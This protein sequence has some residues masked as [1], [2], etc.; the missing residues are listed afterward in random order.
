MNLEKLWQQKG[1]GISAMLKRYRFVLLV[2]LVGAVF[3]LLPS[4]SAGQGVAAEVSHEQDF[5]LEELEDKFSRA[6]SEI[7]GAG[8]V[9]VVLTV[10][11]GSQRILAEDI[12]YTQKDSD[13]EREQATVILAKGSGVQEAVTVQEVYPQFQGALV[14]C[15]GGND[16]DVRLKLTEATVALT[17]LSTDKISICSRGK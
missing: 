4:G 13:L 8:T 17:G 6:L 16:P 14:V 10:K 2:L 12:Q 5:S 9:S 3:L 15:D 7:S 11:A 1:Q